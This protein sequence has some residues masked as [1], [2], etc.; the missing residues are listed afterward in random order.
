MLHAAI[1]EIARVG[2]AIGIG[3]AHQIEAG[4]GIDGVHQIVAGQGSRAIIIGH[5]SAGIGIGRFGKG[6]GDGAQHRG[7]QQQGNQ[8]FHGFV[9]LFMYYP[10]LRDNII[11]A[12]LSS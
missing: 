3:G 11:I 7:A 5:G 9:F 2:A 10:P 8:L 4:E 1:D 6:G 12:Q